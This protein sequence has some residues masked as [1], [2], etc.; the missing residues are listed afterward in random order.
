MYYRDGGVPARSS[1]ASTGLDTFDPAGSDELRFG[2]FGVPTDAFFEPGGGPPSLAAA[3]S[4][5]SSSPPPCAAL[6]SPNGSHAQWPID[7]N[8]S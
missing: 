3:S 8:W 5:S 6:S 2:A 1:S 7:V 4:P